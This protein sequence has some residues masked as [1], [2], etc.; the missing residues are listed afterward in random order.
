MA[1]RIKVRNYN[2]YSEDMAESMSYCLANGIKIY[3]LGAINSE[4]KI[5]I[6]NNGK[7]TTS[8]ESYSITSA[9]DKVWELYC[10]FYRLHK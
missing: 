3:M 1:K 9:T 10:H 8:P 2:V 7:I 5:Q 6:N 4:H